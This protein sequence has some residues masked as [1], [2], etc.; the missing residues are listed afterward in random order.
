VGLSLVYLSE[1]SESTRFNLF[2]RSSCRTRSFDCRTALENIDRLVDTFHV[3]SE[4]SS[5]YNIVSVAEWG[6]AML[7]TPAIQ[8]GRK[9][10][11]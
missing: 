11:W 2:Y 7:R 6:L 10:K 5:S 3:M 9:N 4:A 1:A 8:G